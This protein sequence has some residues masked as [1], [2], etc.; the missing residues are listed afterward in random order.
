MSK[1]TFWTY[2]AGG[3]GGRRLRRSTRRSLAPAPR[4]LEIVK[5]SI[6]TAGFALGIRRRVRRA[7]PGQG[8]C[9][10]PPRRSRATRARRATF[11]ARCILGLVLIE[12]LVI[13]VLLISLILFFCLAVR[14]RAA[15]LAGQAV[16]PIAGRRRNVRGRRLRRSAPVPCRPPI[17]STSRSSLACDRLAPA[18]D[19]PHLGHE[20]LPRQNR[21]PRDRPPG[22][23]RPAPDAG[24][25]RVPGVIVA[26]RMAPPARRTR[27]GSL[28]S[29][30]LHAGRVTRRDWLALAGLGL[31]G[32]CL[33]QYLFIGGLAQTSVANG[34]LIVSATPIVITLLTTAIGQERHRRAALGRRALSLTGIYIVVGRGAHAAPPRC[35]A[36]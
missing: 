17:A 11:A 29:I 27:G 9:A 3:G 13:Y 19:D 1:R 24:V 14:R 16:R 35:A 10:P 31:V 32:H 18:P 33:Y 8:G 30:F 12:S 20:L 36:T 26:V 15:P 6:I 4:A 23:Q 22:V 2:G 28:A 34:S 25:R 5:W 21:L 7:R